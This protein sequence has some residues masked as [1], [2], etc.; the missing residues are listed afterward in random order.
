MSSTI[1]WTTCKRAFVKDISYTSRTFCT[2]SH[3]CCCYV[4]CL[5]IGCIVL[6]LCDEQCIISLFLFFRVEQP[7]S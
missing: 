6:V 1:D 3:Y 5:D 7:F 4:Y 2:V